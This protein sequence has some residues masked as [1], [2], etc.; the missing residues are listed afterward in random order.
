MRVLDIAARHGLFGI[1]VAR[2][3]RQA[4]VVALDWPAVLDVAQENANKAG[5]GDRYTS[6]PGD[7]L[8]WSSAD[9][10]TWSPAHQFPASLRS[11][12]LRRLPK[13]RASLR[14][15][16]RAAA[17]E[18]V[19]NDDRVSPPIPAAFALIMLA[20]TAQGDAY[21]YRELD[22]MYREAGF[23]DHDRPVPNGPHMVVVGARDGNRYWPPAVVALTGS[24]TR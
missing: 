23:A 21:T 17:L 16:G 4:T 22:A 20:T 14:E 7:A 10:T 1:E 19:P 8:K 6:L 24:A 12:D 5:V 3:N 15:G 18:F 9:R 13:S 11:R 2:Q